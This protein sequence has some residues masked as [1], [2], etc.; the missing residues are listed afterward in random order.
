MK[1]LF[2]SFTSFNRTERMG[3]LALLILLAVLITIRAAMP[4]FVHPET[5]IAQQQKLVQAWLD[6]NAKASS[7][8]HEAPQ[9]QSSAD[10]TTKH[11]ITST[12]EPAEH[13]TAS[14]DAAAGATLFPFDPNTIDSAGLRKLGL[15]EKTTSIFL[16]WRDKGKKFYRK[17]ELKK[18]YTLTDE[19][20]N[21]LEPYIVIDKD[22][23]K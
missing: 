22:K 14:Q 18:L 9:Q 17:D 8:K 6:F 10:T 23:L 11:S 19:E 20:Y 2:S 1:R 7:E 16:H 21:R 15:R 12:P 3:I 13:T 4:F 5:D